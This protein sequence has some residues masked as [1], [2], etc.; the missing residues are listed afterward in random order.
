MIPQG[1]WVQEQGPGLSGV[2]VAGLQVGWGWQGGA[3][4]GLWVE[5]GTLSIILLPGFVKASLPCDV[6]Y[7]MLSLHP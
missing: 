3:E 5:A 1:T 4:A 7:S 6:D 2:V